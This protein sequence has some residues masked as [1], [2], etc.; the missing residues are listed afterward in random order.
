MGC[1]WAVGASD[2]QNI[3][4]VLF[5]MINITNVTP[6]HLLLWLRMAAW[7]LWAF[8]LRVLQESLL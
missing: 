2:R 8:E 3:K 4:S 5:T 7:P 1:R 6:S